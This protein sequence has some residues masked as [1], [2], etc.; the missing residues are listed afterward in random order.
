MKEV[1]IMSLIL[2]L[3]GVLFLVTSAKKNDNMAAWGAALAV[4]LSLAGALIM[5]GFM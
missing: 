4:A 3:A 2:S 1:L 5:V